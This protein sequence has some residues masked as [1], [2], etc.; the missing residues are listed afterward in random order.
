MESSVEGAGYE[1]EDLEAGESLF[2]VA[3]NRD[4]ERGEGVIC[5]LS[6]SSAYCSSD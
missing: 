3:W 5:V 6:F 2:E 1:L 4:G